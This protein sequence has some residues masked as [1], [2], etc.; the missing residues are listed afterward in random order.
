[1]TPFAA[2][3]VMRAGSVPGY[4]DDLIST[5]A[6]G[7]SRRLLLR[8]LT[9]MVTAGFLGLRANRTLAV[10]T[11]PASPQAETGAESVTAP[12]GTRIAYWRAG[13]GPPLV[14][15]HGTADNH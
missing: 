5:R 3:G 10:Q 4:F 1:M 15:I 7:A 6:S 12:D 13:E 11:L 2:A 14:L 8:R 9:G